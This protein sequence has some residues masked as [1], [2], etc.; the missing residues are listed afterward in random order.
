MSAAYYSR[1]DLGRT[2]VQRLTEAPTVQNR[3]WSVE[4]LA[5]PPSSGR[6][7]LSFS[8]V[9]ERVSGASVSSSSP[10]Q[11]VPG[12]LPT[13]LFLAGQGISQ[14]RPISEP[15]S[16][17]KQHTVQS[18]ALSSSFS[19]SDDPRSRV[20]PAPLATGPSVPYRAVSQVTRTA[21]ENIS[22]QTSARCSLPPTHS[23]T[24]TTT[25]ATTASSSSYPVSGFLLGHPTP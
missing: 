9:S 4:N 22:P 3:G 5:P 16:R 7:T 20:T 8:C 6:I 21:G 18:S 15:K 23:T 10:N 14:S 19:S 24:T 13:H 17:T 12:Q 2:D 1:R 25:T 11:M